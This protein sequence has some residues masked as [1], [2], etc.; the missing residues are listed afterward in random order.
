MW[1][2]LALLAEAEAQPLWKRLDPV[3]RARVLMALLG[4]V[5]LLLAIVAF[6]IMG[7]RIVRRLGRVS[8]RPLP[9]KPWYEVQPPQGG[10][11]ERADGDSRESGPGE[12]DGP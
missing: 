12:R 10:R 9:H 3:T 8:R 6:I 4:L 11:E 1:Q 2:W 7:A 5:I